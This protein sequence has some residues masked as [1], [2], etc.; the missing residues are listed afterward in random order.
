MTDKTHQILGFTAATATFLA[1]K[2][3]EPLSWPLAASIFIGSVIGSLA[4][5]IDQPTGKFWNDVPLGRV[6]GIITSQALGG[7]RNLSHS[8]LGTFLFGL[9]MWFLTSLIPSTWPLD[10]WVIWFSALIGFVAHLLADS[11]TV[12]GIP[13]FWPFGA[14]M[15][16]PPRPFH[17]LRILTGRW[18]EN[19]VIFPLSFLL[20]GLIVWLSAARF[21]PIFPWLCF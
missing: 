11:V 13:L 19:L 14:N 2:P 17:G 6:F 10:P 20:L 3:E 9:L 18:F 16:F 8:I 4:P 7:H 5:D 21:C 12:L 15:G 1:L